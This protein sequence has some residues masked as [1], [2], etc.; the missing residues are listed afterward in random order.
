MLVNETAPQ[1]SLAVG[2]GQVGFA[3]V[4]SGA[5]AFAG[6]VPVVFP[7]FVDDALQ[8]GPHHGGPGTGQRRRQI[9]SVVGVSHGAVPAGALLLLPRWEVV[10]VGG[11]V[12]FVVGE[13]FP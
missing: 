6:F 11:V 8:P 12:Q 1:L 2:A 9:R 4:C 13:L 7:Q 3:D 10:G 5:E